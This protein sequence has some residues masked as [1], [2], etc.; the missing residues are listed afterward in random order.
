MVWWGDEEVAY[1]TWD[2]TRTIEDFP[3]RF[4]KGHACFKDTWLGGR[5]SLARWVATRAGA[6][7]YGT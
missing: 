7:Q 2:V 5:Q 3:A 1:P 4:Q 6:A